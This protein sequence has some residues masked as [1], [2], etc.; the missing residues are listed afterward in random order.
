MTGSSFT[1][2]IYNGG[3]YDFTVDWGDG[4]S[5]DVT[6]WNDSGKSHTYSGSDTYEISITGTIIGW[7]VDYYA[8][9]NKIYEIKSWGPLQIGSSGS[10][11]RGCNNLTVTATD[12][13]NTTGVTSMFRMFYTCYNVASIPNINQWDVSSVTNMQ[14]MFSNA[15]QFN[16]DLDWSDTSSLTNITNM[17]TN[18]SSFNGSVAG[19]DVSGVIGFIGV[20]SRA[21]SFNQ[22]LDT[23][24]VS[25]ATSMSRM[26]YDCED[27]NGNVDNWDVSKVLD[28]GEVFSGCE[29]FNRD[30][31]GWDTRSATDT[32]G[33][34][35][36]CT[37]FNQD[38][39]SWDVS[40]VRYMRSMF[41]SCSAFNQNLAAWDVSNVYSMYLM[42]RFCSSFNQSFFGNWDISGITQDF[43]DIFEGCALSTA[44]YSTMLINLEAQ[45]PGP[46][47]ETTFNAEPATYN[48]TASAAHS[49]LRNTYDWDI[50]DGGLA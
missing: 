39:N 14:G 2:P 38:L 49:S 43:N 20:F 1:L 10:Q 23:W 24:D 37:V 7:K 40:S 26:F 41:N 17:F 9:R 42:F 44:N 47:E 27:F 31:S 15:Y 32:N 11:F 35:A 5:D 30:I 4:N 48:P 18:A 36:G 19:W 29:S 6:A 50:E 45:Y 21:R 46:I 28:L 22:D 25:N 3:T 33:M 8:D 16:E 12:V 13:L 34:F